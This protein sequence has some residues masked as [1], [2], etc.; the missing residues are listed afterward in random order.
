ML[1][2][3]DFVVGA[4]ENWRAIFQESFDKKDTQWEQICTLMDSQTLIENYSWLG[5]TPTVKEWFDERQY[6]NIAAYNFTVT[7][8][9][10]ESTITVDR[11]IYDDNRLGQ[12]KPR[13]QELGFAVRQHQDQLVF[14]DTLVNGHTTLC[15]DG[16]NYFD[17]SH[18]I[19]QTGNTQANYGVLPLD[20][21]NFDTTFAAMEAFQNDQGRPMGILPSLLVVGPK[22]RGTARA[23]LNSEYYPQAGF[24][25]VGGTG[26]S[27]MT[28]NPWKGAADLL[29]SPYITSSS[30]FLMDVSRPIKPIIFQ[31]RK[32]PEFVARDN[33]VTA[34]ALFL[35]KKLMFGADMRYNTA[36][37]IPQ[38]AYMNYV[39]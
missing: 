31:M 2:S 11:N 17:A 14:H 25:G 32:P 7:N 33:P 16:Q 39:A 6:D 26:A 5:A 21:V 10:W 38:L 36:F 23:L 24:T 20:G 22:L 37:A 13:V 9:D 1:V 28:A 29:V 3:T 18:P 35:Y 8:R 27:Q 12:V 4:Y 30:W 15:F 19:G 34:E